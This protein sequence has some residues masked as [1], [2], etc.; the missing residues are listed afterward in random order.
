MRKTIIHPDLPAPV[1]VVL[2][3]VCGDGC[4][5]YTA[6]VHDATVGVTV[7]RDEDSAGVLHLHGR[8][9][10]FSFARGDDRVYVWIDGRTYAFEVTAGARRPGPAASGA[11]PATLA[12]PMPGTIRAIRAAPG[13][14]FSAHAP[15][16]I[17][18]SMKME[19]TLSAPAAGRVK[20]VRC[21]VGALVEMGATLLEL[22]P[23]TEDDK[24][25]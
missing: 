23:E 14:A 8:A 11:L 19:L 12:A 15:L 9:I 2:Q 7:E 25:S 4:E 20:A 18:E 3:R 10:P 5:S 13:D 6:T 17:I 22:E 1:E 24:V 21:Q 16:V